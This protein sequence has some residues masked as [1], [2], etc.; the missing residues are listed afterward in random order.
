MRIYK[1]P[2]HTLSNVI[3]TH[4]GAK[5]LGC[6]MQDDEIVVWL[7]VDIDA[8]LV[9]REFRI[10]PTGVEYDPYRMNNYVGTVQNRGLVWH[11]FDKGCV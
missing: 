3:E 9:N 6:A 11:I 7:E 1:Y 8:G 10:V 2:L 5:V 4:V